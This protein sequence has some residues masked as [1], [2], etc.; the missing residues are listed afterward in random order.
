LVTTGEFDLNA[1][2]AFRPTGRMA[3]YAALGS[4]PHPHPALLMSRVMGDTMEVVAGIVLIIVAILA[5]VAWRAPRRQARHALSGAQDG[6]ELPVAELM[7]TNGAAYAGLPTGHLLH[8]PPIVT[9][10]GIGLGEPVPL[11]DWLVHYHPHRDNVWAEVVAEFYSTAAADPD[12][13]DYFVGVDLAGL[14]KHF[15]AALMMVTGHGLT[16]GAVRQMQLRHAEVRNSHGEPITPEVYDATIG[17]LATILRRK[18]VPDHVIAQV[19]DLLEPLREVIVE[20][21][22]G[23]RGRR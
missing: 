16:V 23:L 1:H 2:D 22:G 21:P 11:R 14:Q 18:G 10:L 6:V 3:R 12:I 7:W 9:D 19:Q 5:I 17:V 8:G 20:Q 4:A 15:L 13:A